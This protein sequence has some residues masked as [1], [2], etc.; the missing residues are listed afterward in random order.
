MNAIAQPVELIAIS[1]IVHSP[2]QPARVS[3]RGN[4]EE[5]AQSIREV[6]LLEPPIVR[7]AP[8]RAG[9][10]ITHELVAGHRRVA[11]A[12]AAGLERVQ[13]IVRDY[14]DDQV[15]EIQAVENAARADLHPLDEADVFAALVE[16]GRTPAQVADK[17]GRSTPYVLQ[18]LQLCQ[19]VP[20]V[21]K[22]LDEEAITLAIALLIARIPSKQLQVDALKEMAINRD[23]EQPT[24]KRAGELIREKFMLR[25][26]DAPFDRS[27][28]ELVAKAGA[29]SVCPK[30]SGNQA[31]LF[32]DVGSPDV[33]TDPSCY[34]SKLDA[35]LAVIAKQGDKKVLPAAQAKNLFNEYTGGTAYGSKLQS[36]DEDVYTGSGGKLKVRQLLKDQL[37]DDK[38]EITLAQ[39]PHTGTIHDLVPR[40]AVERALTA[41]RKKSGGGAGG[42]SKSSKASKAST[43]KV[44]PQEKARREREA[45]KAD[46]K[47][48]AT[49]LTLA[50]VAQKVEHLGISADGV[51]FDLVL[52]K[53]FDVD[54]YDI[55]RAVLARR[56]IKPK[57][58]SSA[59]LEKALR[60]WTDAASIEQQ[61]AL[62]VEAMLA[63]QLEFPT[64]QDE[65]RLGAL[66]KRLGVD[67]KA[68][69]KQAVAANKAER[70]AAAAPAE[71]RGAAKK[72]NTAKARTKK[73]KRA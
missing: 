46:V 42:S 44:S 25:L 16:R 3:A 39:N 70:A 1:A 14:T 8:K 23:G 72:K 5:L 47:K 27:S 53:L 11:A 26:A 6:G 40:A 34:R 69:E 64:S 59:E 62:I 7:P 38:L 13:C 41:R 31:E 57:N 68:L 43:A 60:Q 29:C 55:G 15:L 56:D 52:T 63:E 2:F 49:E 50:A 37:K 51:C 17:I 4:L 36:L 67:P 73:G 35:H 30:R 20:E 45:L 21:R 12:A 19:L 66:Y 10:G 33:C 48:R 28:A 61:R 9:K 24:A 54:L 58:E 18:R 22:A 71:K 32:S 65:R